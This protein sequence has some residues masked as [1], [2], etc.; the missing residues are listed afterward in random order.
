MPTDFSSPGRSRT[1]RRRRARCASGSPSR[2]CRRARRADRECLRSQMPPGSR[3]SRASRRTAGCWCRRRCRPR[4]R[5]A[6]GRA[7]T[8]A[9]GA[10]EHLAAHGGVRARIAEDA[11]AHRGEVA[12]GVAADGVVERHRVALGVQTDRLVARQGRAHGSA[13]LGEQRG[14]RLHAHVLLAAERA[15]VGHQLHLDLLLGHAQETRHLAAVVEDALALGV[16]VTEAVP[17]GERLGERALRLEEQVLDALGA[18]RCPRRRGRSR[19]APRRR[20]PADRP[21]G[22]AG[23]RVGVHAR[24]A[25][26]RGRRTDRVTGQHLVL[27]LDQR[28]GGARRCR[29]SSAAT[30]AS[31]SPT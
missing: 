30:A 22:S 14:L 29:S 18:A 5:P 10:L 13:R 6:R 20:R 21:S 9:G 28:G 27:D 3:R 31:T 17:V 23:S 12:V 19:R 2:R 8:R 1:R 24:G 26:R 11:R 4:R 15:A 25:R 16:E 7:R